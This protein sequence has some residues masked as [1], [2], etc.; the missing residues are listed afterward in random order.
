MQGV[1]ILIE[2]EETRQEES[3]KICCKLADLLL[4]RQVAPVGL[5]G[6]ADEVRHILEEMKENA[7]SPAIFVINTF[8]ARHVLSE[9][10]PLIGD[11]PVLYFRRQLFAG[12]GGLRGQFRGTPSEVLLTPRLA[13][14]WLYGS[15]NSDEI[16]RLAAS[17][18]I[19]FLKDGDFQQIESAGEPTPSEFAVSA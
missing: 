10:D 8:G 14:I 13:S 1:P 9:L 12:W 16:A 6:T 11:V 18:L 19:R 17:A 5:A 15:E 3:L 2:A 4:G 7:L